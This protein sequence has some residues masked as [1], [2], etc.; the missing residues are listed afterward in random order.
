MILNMTSQNETHLKNLEDSLSMAVKTKNEL[1]FEVKIVF[2]FKNSK[3]E[4]MVYLD[5]ELIF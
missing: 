5:F 2:T 3:I 4:F 1:F